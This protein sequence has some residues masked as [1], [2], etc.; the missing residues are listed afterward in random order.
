MVVI[1]MAVIVIL[2]PK[3]VETGVC[4]KPENPVTA[5]F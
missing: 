1:M 2:D 5:V 3:C 4:V